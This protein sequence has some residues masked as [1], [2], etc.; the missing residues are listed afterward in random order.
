MCLNPN[1][2]CRTEYKCNQPKALA[3]YYFKATGHCPFILYLEKSDVPGVYR[4]MSL[5]CSW[6]DGRSSGVG[7]EERCR[8][9]DDEEWRAPDSRAVKSKRKRDKVK[10]TWTMQA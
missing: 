1:I 5:N 3:I 8:K 10:K 6:R 7:K 2:I 9:V 4:W